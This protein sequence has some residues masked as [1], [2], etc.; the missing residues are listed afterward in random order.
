[1]NR[2]RERVGVGRDG[3]KREGRKEGRKERRKV[4]SKK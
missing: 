2:G 3:E 1:M 4:D